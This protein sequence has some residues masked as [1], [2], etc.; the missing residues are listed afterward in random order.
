MRI[1]E[2]GSRTKTEKKK[3]GQ[4]PLITLIVAILAIAVYFTTQVRSEVNLVSVSEINPDSSVTENPT[5]DQLQDIDE[6]RGSGALRTFSGNEFRLLYDQLLQPNLDKVDLPPAITGN[7]QADSI[8]RQIAEER[9]YKLRSNPLTELTSTSGPLLQ[10]SVHQPWLDLQAEALSEGYDISIVSAFRSVDT[11]RSLFLA[12]LAA[13]GV[14][15]DNVAAGLADAEVDT[16]LITSSIP[17]YSKHHTGYTFDLLC[18]GYGF[19]DFVSSDCND[20][21][22]ANNYEKAKKHGFI[23]SYPPDADLQGPDPEAWEYVYVGI[24]LL[25]H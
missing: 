9:G 1:V 4:W 2:P 19:D 6:L 12:R 13:E 7:D 22:E 24:D 16:V 21:L 17:G 3:R 23:P 25:T 20:W 10:D 15:V 14:N 8:I 5:P 11:Q 18:A